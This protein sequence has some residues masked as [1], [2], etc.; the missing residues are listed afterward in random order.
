MHQEIKKLADEALA[1]QNKNQMEAALREISALCELAATVAPEP[2]P[3]DA[4]QFEA[5]EAVQ[6]VER[7]ARAKPEGKA[8]A[9]RK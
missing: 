6:H 9:V 4:E 8:K 2:A 7:N 3:M 1:L 5:A